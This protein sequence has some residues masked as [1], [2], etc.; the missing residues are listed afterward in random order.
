MINLRYEN[1]LK[2]SKIGPSLVEMGSEAEHELDSGMIVRNGFMTFVLIIANLLDEKY[3]EESLREQSSDCNNI[4]VHY[5][6]KEVKGWRELING[7]IK[8]MNMNNNKVLG[9]I[10]SG[11]GGMFGIGSKS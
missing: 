3:I 7:E 8:N 11:S 1:M 5:I 4:V 9:Q 10:T 6:D 2:M